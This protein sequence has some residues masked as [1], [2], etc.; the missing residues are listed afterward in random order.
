MTIRFPHNVRPNAKGMTK[1]MGCRPG[2]DQ[3]AEHL[4]S[5]GMCRMADRTLTPN[6]GSSSGR[7]P[8]NPPLSPSTQSS[9]P[10]KP[11]NP[12]GERKHFNFHQRSS[13][14]Q[15]PQRQNARPTSPIAYIQRRT[16][17][18]CNHV[19]RADVSTT[20]QTDHKEGLGGGT[21]H[22]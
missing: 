19:K 9:P 8:L 13:H 6:N 14:L 22:N 16:E 11:I 4:D 2:M 20:G 10:R 17:R 18:N 5:S 1:K 7:P 12:N 3:T 21:A 15:A